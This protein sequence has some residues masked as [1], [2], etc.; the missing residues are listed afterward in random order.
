MTIPIIA[1]AII[2]IIVG[3]LLI[4]RYPVHML[5]LFAGHSMHVNGE[6]V[7]FIFDYFW[8]SW[9]IGGIGCGIATLAMR[10]NNV[11]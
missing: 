7:P 9:V 8:L 3:Y 4:Q 6:P 11:K 10:G 1:A 5:L 2:T